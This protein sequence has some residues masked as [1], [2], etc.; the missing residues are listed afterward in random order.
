MCSSDLVPSTVNVDEPDAPDVTVVE[1]AVMATVPA[2]AVTVAV[3]VSVVPHKLVLR[4]VA[5]RPRFLAADAV[6]ASDFAKSIF[7]TVR[8]ETGS[9]SRIAY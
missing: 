5:P 2:E 1:P 9:T 7:V 4:K 8:V 6:L 3:T